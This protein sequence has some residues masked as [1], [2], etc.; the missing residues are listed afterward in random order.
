MVLAAGGLVGLG[1]SAAPASAAAGAATVTIV[2]GIPN[3]PV[4]VYVNGQK[5]ISNLQYKTVTKPA[6][7]PPGTYTLAIRKHGASASSAPLLS[8]KAP[9]SAGE[10]VTAVA[11]LT[12]T[13]QPTL[14]LFANPTSPVPPGEAR[15]IMRHVAQGPAVDVYAGSTK[16]VSGLTNPNEAALVVPAGTVEARVTLAGQTSTV[17]GPTKLDLAAG[18]TTV[19]YAVGSP[20]NGTL[21]TVHQ[22]YRVGTSSAAAPPSGVPAGSGGQAAQGG[23]PIAAVA[24]LAIGGLALIGVSGVQLRRKRTR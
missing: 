19:S 6:Q 20:T 10:N 14:T 16:V 2:H 8:G 3:T 24:G 7:L 4:D 22:T 23:V 9:V 15:L 18:T 21:A 5:Q 17:L 13:G 11:H 1:V 12:P